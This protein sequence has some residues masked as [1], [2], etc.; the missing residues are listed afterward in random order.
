MRGR[1]LE[2]YWDSFISELSVNAGTLGPTLKMSWLRST[3]KM[4]TVSRI[5]ESF[6]SKA[7]R[8]STKTAALWPIPKKACSSSVASRPVIQSR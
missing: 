2:V 5:G 7:T 1:L 6:W 4:V 3:G 8:E